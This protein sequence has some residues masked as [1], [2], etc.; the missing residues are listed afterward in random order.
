MLSVDEMTVAYT[1]GVRPCMKR[2][3]TVHAIQ[4]HEPFEVTTM[5]G[6]LKG[7]PGDYLMFGVDGEKYPCDREIWEKSY[8]WCE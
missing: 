8:E 7:K 5:E 1:A 6:T 3:I 4:I 2:P